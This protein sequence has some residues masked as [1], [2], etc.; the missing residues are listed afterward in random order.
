MV[1]I[2]KSKIDIQQV[3]ESVA[4]LQSGGIDVFIGTTRNHSQGK[5]V[6]GLEYEAYEPM[7][8]NIMERLVRQVNETWGVRAS[9]VHRVGSVPIGESS[10]VIAAA[11]AHRDEA[12]KACRFLIDELKRVVP[13]WKREHFEDGTVEWS[14]QSHEQVESQ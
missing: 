7:A 11:S 5:K 6:R 10:V 8:V 13:I 4:G 9:I 12:F 14:R 3:I 1:K 2:T